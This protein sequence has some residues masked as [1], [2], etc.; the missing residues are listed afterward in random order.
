MLMVMALIHNIFNKIMTIDKLTD[1]LSLM[2]GRV[3]N[4]KERNAYP[5]R[6]DGRA[7]VDRYVCSLEPGGLLLR[8]VSG[9]N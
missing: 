1:I 3:G 6:S 7:V 8:S 9:Q 4:S 5:W 2:I